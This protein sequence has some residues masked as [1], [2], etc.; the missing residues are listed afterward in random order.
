MG[1][2]SGVHRD[3]AAVQLLRLLAGFDG[4]A[5]VAFGRGH[6]GGGGSAIEKERQK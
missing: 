2:N 5:G 1:A 6:Q 4:G 3:L